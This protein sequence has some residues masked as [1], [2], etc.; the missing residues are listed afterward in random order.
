MKA[1]KT[2]SFACILGLYI[3]LCLFAACGVRDDEYT[4]VQDYFSEIAESEHEVYDYEANDTELDNNDG[5]VIEPGVYVDTTDEVTIRNFVDERLE[6]VSLVFRLANRP[7]HSD[8]DTVFQRTLAEVFYD[9][10]THPVVLYLERYQTIAFDAALRMAAHLNKIDGVFELAANIDSLVSDPIGLVRWTRDNAPI[11]VELL[12]DFYIY[13]GFEEFF[14]NNMDYF[15]QRSL[16][17][18]DELYSQINFEW[19]AEHGLNLGSLR[20]VL[21]AGGSRSGFG[22][23]VYNSESVG[24][25][26]YAAI[27]A[28][29]GHRGSHSFIIHEFSHSLGNPLAEIWYT[30]NENF[31][32]WAGDS[33]DHI[34]MPQYALS[35]IMAYEYVTRAFELL[36]MMENTES[37]WRMYLINFRFTGF[38]YMEYVLDILIDHISAK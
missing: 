26:A 27:P 4:Y 25:I 19:F 2:K 34:N 14:Q 22:A 32:Q 18:Y 3:L 5:E 28:R 15:L 24:R 31:R 35:M 30:E 10:R 6:L 23:R 13:T 37:N 33:V 29:S 21:H 16:R 36:Y 9:F 11:F 8:V 20:P 17:F 7:G 12:N 38:P 1:F